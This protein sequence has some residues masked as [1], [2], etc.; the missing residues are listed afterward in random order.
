[1]NKLLIATN[2]PSKFQYFKNVFSFFSGSLLSLED[3]GITD[4]IEENGKDETENAIIKARFFKDKSGVTSFA[5]DA[6]LYIPALND[7]PGVK[8]RRWGGK[9]PDTITD[10]EW[11]EYFLS[12]MKDVKDEDRYGRFM[13]SRAIVTP[14]EKVYIQKWRRNIEIAKKPVSN[15]EMRGWPLAN[16]VIEEGTGKS[17]AEVSSSDRLVLEKDNIEDFKNIFNKIYK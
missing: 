5:D 17:W 15:I 1:M 16:W 3:L 11:L 6:G 14:D 10:E 12:R 2:N 13:I 7:E 8:A 4:S 9:F